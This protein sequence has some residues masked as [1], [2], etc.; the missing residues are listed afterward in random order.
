MRSF[1]SKIFNFMIRNGHLFRGQLKKEV[2][3]FNTSIPAFRERCEAG[4]RRFGSV[5]KDITIKNELIEGTNSEWLIPKGAPSDK[6]IMYVHGGG[7]VSGSCNDHRGLISKFAI[8]TGVTNLLYEYR[9]APENPFPAAV[10]DSVKVYKYLLTNGYDSQKIII[11]GESAGGGLCLATLLALKQDNIPLPAAAVAISPWT[12]LTCSSDSYKTKNN[13]SPAPI[14]SWTVFSKYYAAE[15]EITNPLIS[16]LF[17]DLSGLPSI[18]I[19]SGIDDEL[20]EDGEKFYFKAKIEGVDITFKAGEGMLHCYPLL[21]PMF[22]EATDAMNE[23][24]SFIKKHL[25]LSS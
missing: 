5:P 12:D 8:A 4:A 21:A 25:N 2:F 10:E 1:K 9:L 13:V 15:N 19:N 3:D 18:Y 22:P 7:Y 16:P 14:D 23:I 6:L 17:G 11:A 24:V 20:Y